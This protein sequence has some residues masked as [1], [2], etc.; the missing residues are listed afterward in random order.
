MDNIQE[1]G[2]VDFGREP[3]ELELEI[4]STYPPEFTVGSRVED[5]QFPGIVWEVKCILW[6]DY[7]HTWV[8]SSGTSN[9]FVGQSDLRAK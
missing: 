3:T 8:Y 5:K 6:S 1:T 9:V 4:A 2:G 7:F